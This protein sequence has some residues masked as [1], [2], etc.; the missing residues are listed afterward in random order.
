MKNTQKEVIFSKA[1][2]L[3]LY[4]N[5]TLPQIFFKVLPVIFFD[6]RNNYFGELPVSG[7]FQNREKLIWSWLIK[8]RVCK[9]SCFKYRTI[10]QSMFSRKSFLTVVNTSQCL[11]TEAELQCTFFLQIFDIFFVSVIF[12]NTYGKLI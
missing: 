5:W 3:Q 1:T 11:F 10:L 7:C 4:W 9:I 8:W 12:R 6:F 2:D